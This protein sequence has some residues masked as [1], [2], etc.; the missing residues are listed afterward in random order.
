MNCSLTHRAR[1]GGGVKCEWRCFPIETCVGHLVDGVDFTVPS[2]VDG[3]LV[4][5]FGEDFSGILIDDHGGKGKIGCVPCQIN[6]STHVF[7]VVKH[8]RPQFHN[9]IDNCNTVAIDTQ[10][11]YGTCATA[12]HLW[13]FQIVTIIQMIDAQTITMSIAASGRFRS[14]N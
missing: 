8:H 9:V 11:K 3:R 10:T 2:R 1:F 13:C 4:P 12:T 7:F 14:P 5:S 6:R